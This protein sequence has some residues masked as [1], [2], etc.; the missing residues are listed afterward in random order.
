[1]ASAQSTQAEV[2]VTTGA[3]TESTGAVA[4]QIRVFG[5]PRHNLRFFVEGAWAAHMGV[6][7]DAFGA[8]YPYDGR[9]QP[10][11]TYAETFTQ[12]ERYP[13]RAVHEPAIRE[14]TPR[15]HGDRPAVHARRRAGPRRIPARAA[16]RPC[17]HHGLVRRCHHPP[18]GARSRDA[19]R[20]QRR[21]RLLQRRH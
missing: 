3:S 16:V 1:T 19:G 7:S 17:R 11:E 8:A 5:E 9:L 12:R 6:E 20:P 15:V 2:S 10:I 21:A 14:G 4:T 18:A 13:Q